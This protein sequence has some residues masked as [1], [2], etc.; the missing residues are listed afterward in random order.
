MLLAFV[1]GPLRVGLGCL[2]CKLSPR[3]FSSERRLAST[4]SLSFGTNSSFTSSS[5]GWGGRRTCK[6]HRNGTA[7]ALEMCTWTLP[8]TDVA[9]YLLSTYVTGAW[10]VKFCL[11]HPQLLL[12]STDLPQRGRMWQNSN[13]K[14]P[15]IHAIRGWPTR[16]GWGSDTATHPGRDKWSSVA[17]YHTSC[18]RAR[19][20][21]AVPKMCPPRKECL[22]KLGTPRGSARA[23]TV[24][25]TTAVA[26][27]NRWQW[28]FIIFIR[29]NNV[30]DGP[31]WT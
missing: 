19:T 4:R 12:D 11:I 17:K 18:S 22:G 6:L 8:R 30:G 10:R 20:S 23:T 3:D 26:E 21:T 5:F 28:Y 1:P 9:R 31:R 7:H 2:G 14:I 24:T 25:M 13:P 27:G 15:Q 29:M 16:S